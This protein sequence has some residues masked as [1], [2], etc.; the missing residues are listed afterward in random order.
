[1]FDYKS[2]DKRKIN[3]FMQTRDFQ[4]KGEQKSSVNT[5]GVCCP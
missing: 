4:G 3:M 2:Q 1:M 5:P